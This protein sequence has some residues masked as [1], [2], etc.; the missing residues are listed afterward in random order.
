MPLKS[1]ATFARICS[2]DVAMSHKH[3]LHEM[4]YGNKSRNSTRGD[5]NGAADHTG[6]DKKQPEAVRQHDKL[7][8]NKQRLSVGTVFFIIIIIIIN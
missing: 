8:G 5:Q 2:K 1:F 4:N 3:S 7:E 6:S